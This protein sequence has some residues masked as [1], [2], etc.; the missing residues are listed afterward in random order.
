MTAAPPPDPSTEGGHPHA[1]E[2]SD[3][4]PQD[5][6]HSPRVPKGVIQVRGARQNNLAGVD[7]VIPK[8]A[9]TVVTGVS[10]SGKSSL[11]FETLYAEGQ[12]RY[13]ESFSTYARQFLERMD[14]PAVDAIEGLVPAVAIE[15]RNTIRSARSTLATLTELTDHL[16]L[17]FAHRAILHCRVCDAPVTHDL[18]GPSVE[19]LLAAHPDTRVVLTFPFH[20]GDEGD[21][22]LAWSYLGGE[23]YHRVHVDGRT[24]DATEAGLTGTVDVVADRAILRRDDRQR[25]VESLEAAYRMGQGRATVHIEGTDAIPL[26]VDSTH[27]GAHHPAPRAGLFSFSSPLGACPTCNGFGRTVDI[28]MDRVIPD[29]SKS[30]SQGAIRPWTG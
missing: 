2:P 25:L 6:V 18:P 22:S 5:G 29:P 7:V 19:A 20:V 24:V 11:A 17:L 26:S 27:C 30:L 28:D 16:K 23:G 3:G 21:S 13:V 1:E 4:A 9:L 12:R 14:R 8:G 10:G 15:Q